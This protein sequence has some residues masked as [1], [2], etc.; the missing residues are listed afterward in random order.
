MLST[1]RGSEE[2]QVV[3][4]ALADS[5]VGVENGTRKPGIDPGG[6]KMVRP[7]IRTSLIAR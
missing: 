4:K 6:G 7:V 5:K 1:E 3:S 2:R